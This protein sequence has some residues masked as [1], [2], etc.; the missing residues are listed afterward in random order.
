MAP[1]AYPWDAQGDGDV[2]RF[3][4][5]LVLEEESDAHPQTGAFTSHFALYR[6]AMREVGADDSAIGEF[7]AQ[8]RRQGIDAALDDT[9]VPAPSRR[10]TRTTFD[11]IA[12][13]RPHAVAAALALGREHI[14]PGMFRTLLARFAIEHDQAPVLHAYLQRH[15]HLD[16]D[17]H[18][19]MS[20]R[21]LNNLCAGDEA[22]IAEAIA[23]AQYAVDAR[24]AL[25]DGVLA[26][27]TARRAA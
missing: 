9:R 14:I 15:V 13:D 7:V 21:L 10:F 18:A 8:V 19:P 25:W 6:E 11:I 1:A 23:T 16:A 24:L 26:A 2:R 22:R 27:I 4:N 5:E 12:S 17:F 20:L 3:I